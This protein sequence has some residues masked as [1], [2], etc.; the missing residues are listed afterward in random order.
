[1]YISVHKGKE[2]KAMNLDEQRSMIVQPVIVQP[3]SLAHRVSS[4]NQLRD[5]LM[6]RLGA[7]E[8]VDV[9]CGWARAQE[10]CVDS[11][12][13]SDDGHVTVFGIEGRCN[14]S[15][16]LVDGVSCHL[17][18]SCP[19][20]VDQI[21]GLDGLRVAHGGCAMR[22]RWCVASGAYIFIGCLQAGPV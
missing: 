8:K 5:F 1:M 7:V 6:L 22:N 18:L 10:Q 16:T 19:R 2:N 9:S 20:P 21:S 4:E 3:Q 14:G 11:P 12:T 17:L 13:N 15:E